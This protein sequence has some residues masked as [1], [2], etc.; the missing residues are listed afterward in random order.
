MSLDYLVETQDTIGL[1]QRFKWEAGISV[2][3]E[4]QFHF[5]F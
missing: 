5:G 2:E 4:K 1:R 3:Y